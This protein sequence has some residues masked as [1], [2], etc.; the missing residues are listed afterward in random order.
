MNERRRLPTARESANMAQQGILDDTIL[1]LSDDE[2]RAEL[3]EYAAPSRSQ[4][5]FKTR[6]DVSED[7]IVLTL[8]GSLDQSSIQN[9]Q[10]RIGQIVGAHPTK[11]II[12]A[13]DIQS[14]TAEGI[15][16][17]VVATQQLGPEVD[18]LVVGMSTEVGHML[19]TE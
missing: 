1:Y 3:A 9:I 7:R 17:I 13:T 6:L 4:D 19:A 16:V 8:H 14:M 2:L 10:E 15:R 11:V 18:V 5:T 12:D